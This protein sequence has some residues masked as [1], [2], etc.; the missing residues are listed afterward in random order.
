MD[1]A[2]SL[3]SWYIV[4]FFSFLS[5][6][7]LQNDFELQKHGHVFSLVLKI[8]LLSNNLN[9]NKNPMIFSSKSFLEFC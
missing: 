1:A 5:E 9:K 7:S 2:T 6:M 3:G 8:Q 4:T